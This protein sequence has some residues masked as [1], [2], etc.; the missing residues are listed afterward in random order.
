MGGPLYVVQMSCCC[1]AASSLSH[2]VS[3]AF[4]PKQEVPVPVHFQRIFSPLCNTSRLSATIKAC[5]GDGGWKPVPNVSLFASLS[6]RTPHPFSFSLSSEIGTNSI[7]APSRVHT[8]RFVCSSSHSL[9]LPL[10]F[11]FL[12]LSLFVTSLLLLVKIAALLSSQTCL[13]F[14]GRLLV[15]HRKQPLI[16]YLF[17]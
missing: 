4:S 9:S 12:S 8:T 15:K 6:R 14:Q 1:T 13:A 5:C 17:V 3:L 7:A 11:F 2:T 16:S 10:L